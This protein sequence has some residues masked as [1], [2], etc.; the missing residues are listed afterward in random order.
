[1]F[2]FFKFFVC[3]LVIIVGLVLSVIILVFVFM[4]IEFYD[5]VKYEVEEWLLVEV[6]L[7]VQELEFW[8]DF[9]D[10][11]VE[12]MVVN[13]FVWF[14]MLNFLVGWCVLES[15][16]GSVVLYLQGFYV[17]KNFYFKD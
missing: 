13:L 15:G 11:D 9:I 1:M 16:I 10:S 2:N 6:D 14:V 8:L 4:Y 17:Y 5:V 3:I 7:R 12:V